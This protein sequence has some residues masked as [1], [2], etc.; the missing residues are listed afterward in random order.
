MCSYN[1][2]HTMRYQRFDYEYFKKVFPL[3]YNSSNTN[4]RNIRDRFF[5]L[6]CTS[7]GHNG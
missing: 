4:Q 2:Y 6:F 1:I 7:G 5:K 3:L